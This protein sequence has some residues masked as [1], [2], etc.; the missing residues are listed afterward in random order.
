MLLRKAANLVQFANS[1]C[2]RLVDTSAPFN[3]GQMQALERPP[4]QR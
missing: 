1:A 2:K 3:L 4:Q